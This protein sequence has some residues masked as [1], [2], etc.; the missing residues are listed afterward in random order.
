VSDGFV[1]VGPGTYYENVVIDKDDFMLQGAGNNTIID[2]GDVGESVESFG[3]N[4]TLTNLSVDNETNI[5]IRIEGAKT[6]VKNILFR[7]TTGN[8][9]GRGIRTTATDCI[10]TG[11]TFRPQHHYAIRMSGDRTIFSNNVIDRAMQSGEI[12]FDIDISSDDSIV[13]NN[14]TRD[15][16]NRAIRSRNGT[17]DCIVIGNRVINAAGDGISMGGS[18]HIVANNRI[19]D[20]GGTNLSAGGGSVTDGNLTGSAN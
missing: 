19:S 16:G 3:E 10:V 5:C 4:V 12:F 18:D 6:V 7:D 14:T 20:S 1:F 11:C 15:S 13:A 2:G 8:D 9:E 17:G